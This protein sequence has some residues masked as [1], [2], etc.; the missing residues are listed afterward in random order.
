MQELRAQKM[1]YD[2]IADAL[3]TEGLKPRQ[4]ER[5]YAGVV[6]RILKAQAKNRATICFIRVAQHS[7]WVFGSNPYRYPNRVLARADCASEN[8]NAAIPEASAEYL[9]ACRHL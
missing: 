2:K 1:A 3:N 8:K 5:W 9:L 6:Q 7:E 4:G